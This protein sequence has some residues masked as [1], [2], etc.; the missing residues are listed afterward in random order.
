MAAEH[1]TPP[2]NGP[3]PDTA[4]DAAYAAGLEGITRATA[5]L[6]DPADLIR[7]LRDMTVRVAR[8]ESGGQ[9]VG[10]GVLVAPD[11]LLTAGHV[12]ETALE[13][14]T[15][16][17]GLEARF[18]FLTP[19]GDGRAA[20]H[21][22][23]IRVRLTELLACSPPTA[24]ERN[25]SPLSWEAPPDH[26]DYALLRVGCGPVPYR[27]AALSAGPNPR[28]HY[29]L[30][31]DTYDFHR[32][33]L[34]FVVH[35]PLGEPTRVSYTTAPAVINDEG[36]R[37]RY[38]NVNTTPGSSGGPVVDLR[39][40][41]VGI[42]HYAAGAVNQGVPASAIAR[43]VA[44]G[45]HARILDPH[46]PAP[47]RPSG[48]APAVMLS[49]VPQDQ[50]WADLVHDVLAASG[51][52]VLMGPSADRPGHRTVREHVDGGGKVLALVSPAYLADP[53]MTE[54][55]DHI[56][57]DFDHA[58]APSRLVPVLVE[59]EAS[60]SL[61]LLSPVD[62]R[63]MPDAPGTGHQG[64]DRMREAS[65]RLASALGVSPSAPAGPPAPASR[66]SALGFRPG[67]P[68]PRLRLL[69]DRARHSAGIVSGTV[70]ADGEESQFA[71]GL[72][73]TR[74]LEEELLERLDADTLTP[75]VVVGEAG[76]GKTSILWSLARR[77]CGTATGE[78]FF[79]KATWLVTGPSGG[80]R[81]DPGMLVEAIRQA[82]VGGRT[83]TVLIDTVDVL[84]N[85]EDDWERLVT[86]VYAAGDAGAA[87]VMTSRVAEAAE[88]PPEW[89]RLPL[90]DYAT[91]TAAGPHTTSE[92]ERAVLA[93][94]RFFTNDPQLREDL[95]SRMLT[96]VARD[97]SLHP[98]CLRP[99]TLRMLFEVYTPGQVPDVVDTTGLYE[100]YWD[101][102]VTRDRRS[103]D[104]GGNRPDHGRDLGGTAVALALEMLRTGRPEAW[105]DRVR[106]PAGLTPARLKEEA[107]LLEKR[108]VG[109]FANGVFQFFHQTFFEYAASYALVHGRG[110]AGLGA[111]VE[112]LQEADGEDYFLLAVLEQ[113]WLC[114]D[115]TQDAA[116]A[117][118]ATVG[119]LL[120]TI[121]DDLDGERTTVRYGLRRAVLSVCA[122]SSLL[123]EEM[124]TDLLHILG[125]PRLALLALRQFLELLPAPGR[126]FESRDADC[127]KA[128]AARA[129]NAW[130]AVLEVLDRLLPRDPGEVVS[131]VRTTGL[132]ERATE[133]GHELS[134]RVEFA[135]FLVRLLP[136]RPA[137]A[138]PL[139][140]S[141][142]GA[143]LAA[144]N[145]QYAADV[146][147]R[148]AASS[149]AHG[150][151][152]RWA[153]WA[154]ELL[155]DTRV[156][157]SALIKAH[158]SVQLPYLRTLTFPELVDQLTELVPRLSAVPGPTTAD[159][160]L[161]GGLLTA[162]A[163]VCPPKADPGPLVD[164]L[165]RVT[166]GEQVADLSRGSL[167]CLLDSDSPVGR[168][169]RDLAVDWLV[170][171]MPIADRYDR[172][173]VHI[174]AKV[175]RTALAQLDLP[176]YR[177]ADVAGR[178]ASAWESPEGDPVQVWR[179]AGCLLALLVRGAV[180]GVPEAAA[181]LGEL[182][183]GFAVTGGDVAEWV[184]PYKRR[185]ANA[186][187]AGV[188]MDLL[189][190]IGELRQARTM[191]VNGVTLDD[192]S[193]TRLARSALGAL[194]ATVPA[195]RPSAMSHKVRKRL[196]ELAE[197]LV[198]LRHRGTMLDLPWTELA[199]WIDRV[200]DPITLGWMVEL[201]GA[202]LE[203]HEYPPAD[204]LR[205]LRAQCGAD[206]TLDGGSELGRKARLWCVWWYSVH[207]MASDVPEALRVAFHEPVDALTIIKV[208][209]FVFPDRRGTPL[210]EDECA[211]LLLD[212]GRRLRES[213][214]GSARRK[215]VAQ[216]WRAAMWSFV[217]GSGTD[218]QLRIVRELPLLEDAFAGH[219]LQCVPVNR[220]PELRAALKDVAARPDL[221]ARLQ[222]AMHQILDQYKR[223]SSEGGWPGLFADLARAGG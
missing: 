36:T 11:I 194:G 80:A 17:D 223:H 89:R 180:A 6:V 26:L 160:S 159:R 91:N 121:S 184:E 31:P 10:T 205:L 72:Y 127:L 136:A 173:L 44:G 35:H 21:E 87:V 67:D 177:V 217:P 77:R 94:S 220:T 174:R 219:L 70:F 135:R 193:L 192:A 155:G 2:D 190:R 148:M 140:R 123:T 38:Q 147:S 102:R 115:R 211:D 34:L 99:L 157:S 188:M 130:L 95:I 208:S 13:P 4:G 164:L 23:G 122:Q 103:W 195:I 149:A 108:G 25:A 42:H 203:R 213:T 76:C 185:P 30:E 71:A 55:R 170:Q 83:V 39:G 202:G 14:G 198:V 41:L 18:D 64:R 128:A 32:A 84:V 86:V 104:P 152:R 116:D 5:G 106:L 153:D 139:V 215:D 19:Y 56:V 85:N 206:G 191:L 131:A 209:N 78:V 120:K 22:R 169:V 137:D 126:G 216:A 119:K 62:L 133:G 161:F 212:V 16:P 9:P 151:P 162:S 37:I 138:F 168:A 96:I 150:A 222:R 98:L 186:V 54:E 3:G 50:S 101:H 182:P 7:V 15:L 100:T 75:L 199:G 165:V 28:G 154:D 117:A 176:A 214:L 8:V 92:F 187:E 163:D 93:H 181:A 124:L 74:D 69:S 142:V 183:S 158:T 109:H 171:G 114:A 221:G 61:A 125:S 79:L 146:L 204:A 29:L 24:A 59:G 47:S 178:A 156:V 200:P 134:T 132:L 141:V 43:S 88:L 12:L 1:A 66:E 51:H 63:G 81:V 166:G 167:V 105:V 33:N 110:A 27:P 172:E 97:I 207:G 73:V 46:P 145:H 179:S 197:L 52:Q 20:P 113:A 65:V 111:L 118:A 57:H 90:S 218:T 143:A 40:R 201:V 144:G 112:R 196:R 68:L 82:R 175:A 48:A 129:D 107:G 189:V 60:G 53:G 58:S 210:T 45:P 49:W